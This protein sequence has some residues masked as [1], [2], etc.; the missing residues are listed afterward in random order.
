M[1]I[2][3]LHPGEI[4]GY[5]GLL[6]GGSCL[7]LCEVLDLFL[8]NFLIDKIHKKL[9]KNRVEAWTE[10]QKNEKTTLP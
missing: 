7:T 4:G 8:Y 2:I 5:M 1:I 10:K 6:I 9:R 3:S